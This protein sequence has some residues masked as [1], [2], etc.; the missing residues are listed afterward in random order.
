M[1]ERILN[2]FTT[3][4]TYYSIYLSN[5]F[6]MRERRYIN[7]KFKLNLKIKL[8]KINYLKNKKRVKIVSFCWDIMEEFLVD[9][10]ISLG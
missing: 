5:V 3:T 6:L 7:L 8:N 9:G 10:L 2:V 1:Q 4:S